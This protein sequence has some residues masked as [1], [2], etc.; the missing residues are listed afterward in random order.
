MPMMV[1]TERYPPV[2]NWASQVRPQRPGTNALGHTSEIRAAMETAQVVPRD[3]LRDAG[4]FSTWVCIPG[5]ANTRVHLLIPGYTGNRNGNTDSMF[6]GIERYNVSAG[7]VRI[8]GWYFLVPELQLENV[9]GYNFV[10]RVPK[11]RVICHLTIRTH[12]K[13]LVAAYQTNWSTFHSQRRPLH[14]LVQKISIPQYHF[15]RA[16]G[17]LHTPRN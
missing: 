5:H 15:R 14:H 3:F 16:I 2:P 10:P 8:G 13:P 4:T 12:R 11:I 6:A 1:Q 9:F 17:K 7:G